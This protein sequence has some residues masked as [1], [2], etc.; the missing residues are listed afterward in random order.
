MLL[1]KLLREVKPVHHVAILVVKAPQEIKH[2]LAIHFNQHL[3]L[4]KFL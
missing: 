4:C 3:K 1:V 2:S